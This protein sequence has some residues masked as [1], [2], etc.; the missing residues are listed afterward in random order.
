M[1]VCEPQSIWRKLLVLSW[2]YCR[3]LFS[4]WISSSIHFPN[5]NAL[6]TVN[7]CNQFWSNNHLFMKSC[8]PITT[9]RSINRQIK[10]G[11]NT[12]HGY[13]YNGFGLM[14]FAVY[15]YVCHAADT[16][17]VCCITYLLQNYSLH[18]FD[19]EIFQTQINGEIVNFEIFNS[20]KKQTKKID[21]TTMAPQV[22]LFLF[23]FWENCRHQ[24]DISKLTDLYD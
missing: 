2:L 20:P 5:C 9:N 14:C 1:S 3:V 16:Y 7:C 18:H 24:K 8:M 6:K 17:Y 21:F 4:F 23:V 15:T 10:L 11:I 22:E 13:R 19:S 12:V